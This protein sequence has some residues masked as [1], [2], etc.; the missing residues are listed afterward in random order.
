LV[1]LF[2]QGDNEWEK[3]EKEK[4]ENATTAT[5]RRRISC[6]VSDC[7]DENH[8]GKKVISR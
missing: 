6:N 4:K 1:G 7:R 3:R 8:R 5:I 2:C